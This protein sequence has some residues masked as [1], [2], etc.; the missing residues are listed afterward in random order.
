MPLRGSPTELVSNA[1]DACG[2]VT[3]TITSL[4]VHF[5]GTNTSPTCHAD[6]VIHT[7]INSGE[8]FNYSVKFPIRLVSRPGFTG[9]TRMCSRHRRGGSSRRRLRSDRRRWDREYPT[10]GGGSARAHH[11]CPRPDG[12]RKSDSRRKCA[13]LGPLAHRV[14]KLV[15][16]TDILLAPAARASSSSRVRRRRSIKQITVDGATRCCSPLTIPRRSRQRRVPSR[17]GR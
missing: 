15:T 14:G 9:T 8:T 2:D 1:S 3:M 10:G 12:S 11:D 6:E 4:N 16:Q 17:C 5:H 13:V 7:L